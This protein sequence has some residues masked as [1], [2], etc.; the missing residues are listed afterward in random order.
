MLHNDCISHANLRLW[1]V[2]LVFGQVLLLTAAVYE[3]TLQVAGHAARCEVRVY[4]VFPPPVVES[5][6]VTV[7]ETI[8]VLQI[9]ILQMQ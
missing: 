2:I 3:G 5:R 7:V 6:P 8:R 4:L 9:P 1:M